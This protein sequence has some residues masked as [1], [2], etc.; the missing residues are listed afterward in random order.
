MHANVGFFLKEYKES[1]FNLDKKQAT[2][3]RA[4]EANRLLFFSSFNSLCSWFRQGQ[5]LGVGWEE[6]A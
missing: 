2:S 5:R 4:V 1:S 6:G 3:E